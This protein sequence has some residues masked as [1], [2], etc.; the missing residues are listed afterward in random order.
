M[1]EFRP[2][3]PFA[4]FDD[5]GARPGRCRLFHGFVGLKEWTGPEGLS[6]YFQELEQAGNSGLWLV[7]A[8]DYESGYCLEPHLQGLVPAS[9][10]PLLSVGLFRHME[11]L[12]PEETGQFISCRLA[13]IPEHRR[14]AGVCDIQASLTEVAFAAAVGRIQDYISAGDCY[15]VNFTYGLNCRVYGDPFAL[16]SRLRA[17]QPVRYGGYLDWP[18]HHVLSLS[19]ELFLER[20]GSCLKAR[21]MKGTAP[22]SGDPVEDAS[23]RNELAASTKNR[24]ENVMIVDLLRNDMGRLAMPGSVRVERLCEV[25]AYPTVFQMVSDVSARVEHCSLESVFRALFP[26][27]SITGAPKI[28]AMEII[29]ELETATRGLYT[30]SLG[31][32]APN[33]DFRLNVAIRTLV[34]E[35]SRGRLGIG[36]GIVADSTPAAEWEECRSKARFL[37][38]LGPSFELIESLRLE[39]GADK[40]YEL[41]ELHL[42]RL[43]ASAASLGFVCDSGR[44]RLELLE[45]A[46]AQSVGLYKTRLLLKADGQFSIES[47]PLA[48]PSTLAP[49]VILAAERLTSKDPLLEHKTTARSIYDRALAQLPQ[50]VFDAIFLNERDELCEGARS[51]LFLQLNGQL[52]TPPLVC[53]LLDGVMR[54]KLLEVGKAQ[55]RVLY[56]EDLQIAEAIYLSNAVRGLFQVKLNAG[57]IA[58]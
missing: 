11:L 20:Q 12:G 30:G 58:S 26:C 55:E 31:W 7:L 2:G 8:V 24:A 49:G 43:L 3:E 53:G 1:A 6:D 56:R 41:L 19:P 50:G 48:A 22:R 16:Y 40:P 27:G 45:H 21:P 52:F 5:D 37:T 54:R 9:K 47:S 14:V 32:V 46:A 36:A 35:E 33:G 51:N 28:R 15:Q 44:L 57:F 25:E 39:A 42:E 29:H 38:E 18:G 13:E 23:L 34:L 4:L 10:R 17:A